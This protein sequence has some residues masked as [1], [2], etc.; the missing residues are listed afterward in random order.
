MLVINVI[1]IAISE[2]FFVIIREEFDVCEREESDFAIQFALPLSIDIHFRHLDDIANLKLKSCLIVCIWNTR[3][4][5]SCEGW[6]FSLLWRNEELIRL[7]I[8]MLAELRRTHIEISSSECS[9]SVWWSRNWL[10][11]A[12]AR[13]KLRVVLKH[14]ND[15]TN[16]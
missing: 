16:I 11:T 15:D 13:S 4:L 5:H 2:V 3:L 6:Q 12:C 10:K 7:W 8:Q 9:F 14:N 1:A